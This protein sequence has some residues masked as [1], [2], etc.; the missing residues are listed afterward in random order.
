MVKVFYYIVPI[1]LFFI[2]CTHIA[3]KNR[4]FDLTSA[5]AKPDLCEPQKKQLGEEIKKQPEILSSWEQGAKTIKV[6]AC[7]KD[8]TIGIKLI[9]PESW[10][11]IKLKEHT[12]GLKNIHLRN[13]DLQKNLMKEQTPWLTMLKYKSSHKGI[14]PSIK[15]KVEIDITPI[16][17]RDHSQTKKMVQLNVD[18]LKKAFSSFKVITPPELVY[19]DGL[20]GGYA[21]V[22]YE[23]QNNEGT[24]F[25][26]S[27]ELW[28]IPK[29]GYFIMIGAATRVDEKIGTRKEIK[30]IIKTIEFI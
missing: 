16:G 2:S 20:K 13:R 9:K 14:N 15:I 22:Q 24:D 25:P 7:F 4:N 1:L 17:N 28:I 10:H 6:I 30:D 26:L 18:L 27:S 3:K 11:Y 12:P 5:S 29:N 19:V 21:H 8:R 23:V